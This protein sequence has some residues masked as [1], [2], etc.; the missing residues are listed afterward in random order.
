[1]ASAVSSALEPGSWKIPRPTDGCAVETAGRVFVLGAK[2]NSAER[3]ARFVLAH[4]GHEVAQSRQLPIV[5]R[6]D[7]DVAELAPDR[8]AGPAC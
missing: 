3:L 4:V 5:A 1:M 6:L 8:S 2:L 7:D